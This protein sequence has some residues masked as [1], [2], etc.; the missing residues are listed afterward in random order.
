[1]FFCNQDK[2]SPLCWTTCLT[3]ALFHIW[4]GGIRSTYKGTLSSWEETSVTNPLGQDTFSTIPLLT[5]SFSG[6]YQVYMLLFLGLSNQ[7][8]PQG[9]VT[10]HHLSWFI[11]LLSWST[12]FLLYSAAWNN[13]ANSSIVVLL[14]E[15]AFA[16]NSFT[17][18]KLSLT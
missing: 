12:F 13:T 18:I 11:N 7:T 10:A 17:I 14:C 5:E 3:P 2:Y 16:V 4:E 15:G 9:L 1:M 6:Q 8:S